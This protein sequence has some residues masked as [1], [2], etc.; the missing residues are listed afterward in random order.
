MNPTFLIYLSSTSDQQKQT[1]LAYIYTFKKP[2]KEKS[3][4]MDFGE[5]VSNQ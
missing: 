3:L 1:K 2:C 5:R 4:Q